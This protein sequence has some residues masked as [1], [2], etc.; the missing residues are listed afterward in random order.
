MLPLTGQSC[1]PGSTEGSEPG[2]SKGDLWR[3]P[4]IQ[5]SLQE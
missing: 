3:F 5:L 2:T 1:I 4:F